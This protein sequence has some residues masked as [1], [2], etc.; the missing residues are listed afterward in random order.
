[1]VQIINHRN[2]TESPAN[3]PSN[4]KGCIVLDSKTMDIFHN[5]SFVDEKESFKERLAED[6]KKIEER[7]LHPI[8]FDEIIGHDDLKEEIILAISGKLCQSERSKEYL[9]SID[10]HATTGILMEGRPGTGK[11]NILR[12]VE[13]SLINHPDVDCKYISCGDFQ[14]QVGKNA[15]MIDDVF[16]EARSTPKK[17][18]V[19]LIDEIDSILR[20]KRGLLN[21]AERTNAMQTNMDG[22]KDSSKIIIIATTNCI[23]SMEE[24]SVSRFITMSLDYPTTEERK[25]FIKRYISVIPMSEDINIDMLANC[26]VG[27]SGRQFRDIGKKLNRI[28][29]TTKQPISKDRMNT[30]LGKYSRIVGRNIKKM[31]EDNEQQSKM[32]CPLLIT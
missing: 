29:D 2:K 18:Y 16:E 32:K 10:D 12:A 23:D 7:R 8:N 11:S 15:Q 30:E 22:M 1:M 5:K 4:D 26:T 24:A 27:F 13:K 19:M 14:G 31:L 25:L 21:D 28:A 9:K 17:C 6:N 20:K 3:V